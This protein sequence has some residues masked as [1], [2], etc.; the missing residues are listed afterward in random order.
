VEQV[1]NDRVQPIDKET[2]AYVQ[3]YT[4][5]ER[6]D[7]YVDLVWYPR[8][9]ADRSYTTRFYVTSTDN[10]PYDAVLGRIDAERYTMFR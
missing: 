9:N 5:G 3:K 8:S 7:G 6:V 10:P 2:T 1:L 4:F